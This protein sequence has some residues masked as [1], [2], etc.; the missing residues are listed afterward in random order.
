MPVFVA[1]ALRDIQPSIEPMQMFKPLICGGDGGNVA[2]LMERCGWGRA[3]TRIGRNSEVER[4][5]VD[6]GFIKCW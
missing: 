2:C 3:S 4:L 5:Y 6:G 1:T